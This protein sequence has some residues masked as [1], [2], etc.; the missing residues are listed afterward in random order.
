MP[1][2]HPLMDPLRIDRSAQLRN[3]IDPATCHAIV[4]RDGALLVRDGRL[5]EREPGNHP[6]AAFTVYLGRDGDKDLVALVP[7][8]EWAARTGMNASREHADAIAPKPAEA[9]AAWVGDGEE[10][11]GLRDAIHLFAGAGEAGEREHELAATAVAITTWHTNHPRCAKCGEPTRV[12]T[13]GWVRRCDNDERD[14]YP[15]TDAAIIVA[16]T[17]AEDRLLMAHASYWSPGRFSHLAG[18]VEPGESFE[19]A[20][21]REVYEEASLK[22]HDLVYVGSQPWPFPASIMVGFTARVDDPNFSLDDDEI[23]EAHFVTRA[24]LAAH[25]ADGSMIVAPK[26]SIARRMMDDW[27]GGP[28]V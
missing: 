7:D 26:G 10:M 22:V 4:V 16:I 12:T 15:R 23:T 27:Y 13:G 9:S 11:V 28:V 6:D 18:Y 19:Q 14:H 21:H 24:Q 5:V 1:S 25:V 2:Q 20:V 8:D 3:K 17:D